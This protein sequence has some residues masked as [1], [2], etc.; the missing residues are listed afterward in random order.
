MH[1][2]RIRILKYNYSWSQVVQ[3]V[4][5]VGMN[6]GVLFT[7]CNLQAITHFELEFEP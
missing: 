7:E 3:R 6:V 5:S 4:N 2:I 1:K